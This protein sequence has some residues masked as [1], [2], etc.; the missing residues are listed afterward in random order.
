MTAAD[1]VTSVAP[2]IRK[3]V[4]TVAALAALFGLAA[5]LGGYR[6]LDPDEGRNAEVAREMARGDGWVVPH[7]NGLPYADKPVLF[8]AT[9]GASIKAFGANEAAA[10]LPAL[11]FTLLTLATVFWF[12]RR[13]FGNEAAWTA[14]IATA[15]MPFT[16]AYARTVIFDSALTLWVVLALIGFYEA[17][18]GAGSDDTRPN[19][20]ASDRRD[21]P[22]E[23]GTADKRP[24]WRALAWAAMALG[25]LTKGPVAVAL[26]LLVTVPYAIWRRRVRFLVDAVAP[27]LFLVILLPWLFAMSR[28]VP[29][30]LEY[31]LVTET[32]RRLATPEL[33]RTEPIWYFLI[34]LPAAALPWSVVAAAAWWR[35]RTSRP[36][37]IN[38]AGLYLALWL[39]VPLVFFSLSQSKRPQYILPLMPAVGLAVAYQWSHASRRIPSIRAGAV[40][41]LALA[42]VLAFTRHRM[43]SWIPTTPEVAEAIPGTALA[44]ALICFVAALIAW[45]GSRVREV[46]LLGFTLPVAAIPTASHR[47]MDAIAADR[48]AA[49]L[50]AAIAPALGPSAE[51]VTVGTFP[52]SLPFYL[53]RTLLL[54]SDDAT[55]LTSNYLPL[56]PEIWQSARS[57]VRSRAW[58]MQ[59]AVECSGQPRVFVIANE[60]VAARDWAAQHLPLLVL[61]RKYSAWGPCGVTGLA[62]RRVPSVGPFVSETG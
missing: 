4:L 46:A 29:G 5:G 55:E 40:V 21:L 28:R 16:L 1:R 26:P 36:P 54:A 24:L 11:V 14:T 39:L 60:D 31:A 7:L 58:W 20:V 43:V 27:L 62:V 6:L 37:T 8:F 33:Q 25:V 12:A 18:E 38:R 9:V 15:T 13:R 22:R 49:T 30:F 44:L 51:V 42:G 41:L 34:I 32:G 35:G 3:A 52:L 47:L 2:A 56:H 59:A 61:T 53:D 50:A 45:A 10:R 48:S 57:T 23:P 19:P 17:I